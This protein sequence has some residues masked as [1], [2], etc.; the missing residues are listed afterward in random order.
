V[1]VESLHPLSVKTYL[2]TGLSSVRSSPHSDIR[3]PLREVRATCRLMRCNIRCTILCDHLS[4]GRARKPD[5]GIY[6]IVVGR[7]SLVARLTLYSNPF[8]F[9]TVSAAGEVRNVMNALAASV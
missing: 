4:Y 3:R 1:V 9:R 7:D 8:A 6:E 5:N 2:W